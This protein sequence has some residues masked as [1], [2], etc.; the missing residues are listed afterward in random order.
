ML[1]FFRRRPE[2][3]LPV[4]RRRLKVEEPAV[5][6]AIGDIHGCFDQL[7]DLLGIIA[8]DA[9]R[10]AGRCILVTLGD[11]VDRGPKSASVL[12]WLCGPAPEGFERYSLAGNHE[13]MML[14]FIGSPSPNS[15]WLE[16]GGTETLASYGID[17]RDFTRASP[18]ERAAILQACIPQD[19][20]DLLRDLPGMIELPGIVFVHAGIRPGLALAEQDDDDL[21]WIREPFLSTAWDSGPLL[22]HGHTPAIA[23]VVAGRRICVDTGAFATGVLT[24]VRMAGTSISFLQTSAQTQ[25]AGS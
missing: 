8:N 23:P 21:L 16:F 7:Q 20:I 11:Y 5:V 3:V 6:Y 1:G 14:D 17:S 13:A 15:P 12:D 9:R 22:V 25:Q 24:A 18:R 2:T 10:V 4:Q 19:H